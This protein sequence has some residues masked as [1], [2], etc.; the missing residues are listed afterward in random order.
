MTFSHRTM[1]FS[2]T[3]HLHNLSTPAL[4]ADLRLCRCCSASAYGLCLS[5]IMMVCSANGAVVTVSLPQ[6][7]TCGKLQDK[8][9]GFLPISLMSVDALQTFKQQI[10][11]LQEQLQQKANLITGLQSQIAQAQEIVKVGAAHY[12]GSH[13]SAVSCRPTIGM[14]LESLFVIPH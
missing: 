12:Y 6:I 13:A 9:N 7:P 3:Q 2:H 14:C 1:T 10:K 4:Q 11:K 5:M 8:L